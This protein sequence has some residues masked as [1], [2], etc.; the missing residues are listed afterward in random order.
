[1]NKFFLFCL[2]LL[3]LVNSTTEGQS[4]DV[5]D[6]APPYTH[7]LNDGNSFKPIIPK[8]F[9]GC[10]LLINRISSGQLTLGAILKN[11]GY[12]A[13][14]KVND[15][16]VVVTIDAV[17]E[18]VLAHNNAPVLLPYKFYL[19][20]IINGQDT[21][22]YNIE[23]LKAQDSLIVTSDPELQSK[24]ISIEP[25][26]RVKSELFWILFDTKMPD[27]FKKIVEKLATPQV[28]ESGYYWGLPFPVTQQKGRRDSWN[29][30]SG[31]RVVFLKPLDGI[32]FASIL[33]EIKQYHL[34]GEILAWGYLEPVNELAERSEK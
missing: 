20:V 16:N 29:Q 4:N 17:A 2:P 15:S 5:Q 24:H 1:M 34:T 8:P 14:I 25:M 33:E 18:G 3:I 26:K 19:Y 32:S 22:R 12:K 13:N 28:L 6:T 7:G 9:E 11:L 30:F 31:R 21:A 27:N 23:Y 10:Q